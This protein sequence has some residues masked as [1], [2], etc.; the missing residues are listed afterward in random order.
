MA[1]PYLTPTQ[2]RE[3]HTDLV[4]PT[5][6]DTK[7]TELVA[8]FEKRLE[9]HH[10]AQTPREAVDELHE[11]DT[12]RQEI[13]LAHSPLID[14]TAVSHDGQSVSTNMHP[15][16]AT[17]VLAPRSGF[18]A[19]EWLFTYDYGETAPSA[20]ILRACALFVWHEAFAGRNPD[21]GNAFARQNPELGVFERIST[22]DPSSGRITGWIDVD[23]IIVSALAG[24]GLDGF[25]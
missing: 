21:T 5:F 23:G 11:L 13:A 19:G 25:A 2:V 9:L 20:P 22:P 7:L 14:V 18:D 6:G 24:A 12:W 3:R 8:E 16:L 10:P 15:D 1:L 4:A 17:G